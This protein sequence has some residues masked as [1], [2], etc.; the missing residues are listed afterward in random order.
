M[1]RQ[2]L[3]H[4]EKKIRGERKFTENH[5]KSFEYIEK[6]IEVVKPIKNV[7]VD[8]WE[9][10]QRKNNTWVILLT[11]AIEYKKKKWNIWQYKN[12]SRVKSKQDSSKRKMILNNVLIWEK[13]CIRLMLSSRTFSE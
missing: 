3:S 8:T 12:T 11:K 1:H 2:Y 10:Q 9:I 5:P 4:S 13:Y 6:C 7:N